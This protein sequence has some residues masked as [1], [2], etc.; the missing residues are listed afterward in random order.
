MKSQLSYSLLAITAVMTSTAMPAKAGDWVREQ[1]L[2][3]NPQA[4]CSD[5]VAKKTEVNKVDRSNSS[6]SARSSS[7]Q[8]ERMDQGSYTKEDESASSSSQKKSRQ[9]NTGVGLGPI[10]VNHGEEKFKQSKQESS[11]SHKLDKS[12]DNSQRGASES[13]RS[14]SNSSSYESTQKTIDPE[15]VGKN[16]DAFVEAASEVEQTE[17]EE[18]TNRK[19]IDAKKDVKMEQIETQAEQKRYQQLMNW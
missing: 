15:A 10:S 13:S 3:Q 11:E 9:N 12:H 5:I 18:R 17:M 4:Y 1:A 7:R 2:E 14:S 6:E 16:C 8:Y 19:A